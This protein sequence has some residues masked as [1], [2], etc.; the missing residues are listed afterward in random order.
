IDKVDGV[1]AIAAAALGVIDDVVIDGQ[2]AEVIV[3]ADFVG[4]E[5]KLGDGEAG[6]R[7][8]R[9][10]RSLICFGL[11]RRADQLRTGAQ[12]HIQRLGIAAVAGVA[13]G[14]IKIGA[15]SVVEDCR[16]TIVA[17]VG[18]GLGIR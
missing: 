10:G 1:V 7:G 3:L 16:A 2:A 8:G 5:S 18:I 13:S 14:V 12:V 9:D 4:R 6:E 11:V 15:V 17:T